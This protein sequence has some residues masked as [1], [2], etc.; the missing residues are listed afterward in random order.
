MRVAGLNVLK[1]GGMT[2]F[3]VRVQK[4]FAL[5]WSEPGEIHMTPLDIVAG[6]SST[7][8]MIADASFFSS[9]TVEM[10]FDTTTFSL[11][12]LA[13]DGSPDVG[14]QLGR[15]V[16]SELKVMPGYNRVAQVSIFLHKSP[17][18]V[19]SLSDL[20]GRWASGSN[21]TLAIRGPAGFASPGIDANLVHLVQI[22]GAS[23]GLVQS[24]YISSADSLVGYD[25]ATG[26][27]CGCFKADNVSS[28]HRD[29]SPWG[30]DKECDLRSCLRGSRVILQ[31]TLQ[32]RLQLLDVSLDVNSLHALEYQAKLH[33][34]LIKEVISCK[35]ST[36]LARVQTR[37]GMWSHSDPRRS[38]D[39]SVTLPAAQAGLGKRVPGQS[40]VF[41]PGQPQPG[42]FS[43]R[44][45]RVLGSDTD[46]DCCFA[47]V[48][49]AA[50]CYYQQQEMSYIPVAMEGNMTLVMGEFQAQIKVTQDRVPIM[51]ADDV[52][53]VHL[54]PLRLTCFDFDFQR[55]LGR[56]VAL[57]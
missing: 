14:L 40:S 18:S 42:Q 48:L 38:E 2:E 16:I 34:M 9:G 53:N 8:H 10:L 37:P 51:F 35:S 1:C 21:Q 17:D 24:A 36:K 57:S 39:A 4:S 7:L 31:N 47:T 13:T 45:C 41:L 22:A 25:P 49:I 20:L 43:G 11:H 56:E 15:V 32:H 12:P 3:T 6:N 33:M 44:Q 50:A 55:V 52:P 5:P 30:K 29:A 54:G 19:N 26:R 46:V 28:Y 27:A 23:G